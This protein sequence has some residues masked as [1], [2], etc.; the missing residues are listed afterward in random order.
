MTV[1]PVV[2]AVSHNPITSEASQRGWCDDTHVISLVIWEVIAAFMSALQKDMSSFME[3]LQLIKNMRSSFFMASGELST[4][5][6][7]GVA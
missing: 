1:F 3:L 5:C 2:Q 6:L 7:Q 4:Y